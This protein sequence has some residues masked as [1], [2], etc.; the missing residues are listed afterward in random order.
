MAKATDIIGLDCATDARACIE[1]VLRTRLAEMC[2]LRAAALDW[3]TPDG[4]HDM[5]VASRRLRSA[6]R[7]FAPYLTRWLPGRRLRRLAS[8]LG[9]VR[10]ED[11]ALIALDQLVGTAEPDI[12]AGLQSLIAERQAR[13]DRARAQLMPI[14]DEAKLAAL[15]AK[16]QTKLAR[17]TVAP[18]TGRAQ[19]KNEAEPRSFR[20]V[21]R[22]VNLAQLKELIADGAALYRP[23]ATRRLHRLRIT[24][25]RLRYALELCA[26]CWDDKLDDAAKEV[27]GLQKSLGELHDCDVWIESLGARLER[28]RPESIKP[29]PPRADATQALEYRAAHWLLGRF[30]TARTKHYVDALARWESW[31]ATD[32]SAHLRALL[33]HTPDAA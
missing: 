6:V 9:A 21:G 26:Q 23:H 20:Q 14:L 22:A 18:S 30:V 15:Q 19:H 17:A 8:A 25:K 4:V 12:A 24:A 27:A 3:S 11:V 28:L 1:L 32:F 10:D 16:F 29:L 5:R 7:D 31:A 13:R 33:E 2:E